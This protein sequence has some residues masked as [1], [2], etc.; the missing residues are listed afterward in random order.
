M[1]VKTEYTYDIFVSYNPIDQIWVDAYL[2]PRLKELGLASIDHRD[3]RV[4]VP[5]IVNIEH[6]IDNSRRILL[7]ITPEWLDDEWNEF[8]GILT[9]TSDPSGRQQRL[10][11]LILRPCQP[12]RRIS[13]LTLVDFTQPAR[14]DEEMGRLL[15]V[16]KT[17]SHILVNRQRV[18][19]S[20][21]VQ[22]LYGPPSNIRYQ[23][24]P[25]DQHFVGRKG[26]I[27]ELLSASQTYRV[28]SILGIPGVGKTALMR[29][30]VA[31]LDQSQVFW[32]EFRPGLL[33]L[34]DLLI[35][36]AR[37]LDSQSET[38]RF[39]ASAM[40]APTFSEADRISLVLS[41]L[42]ANTCSLFFDSVH[43]VER[44]SAIA[45]FLVLVKEQL[46]RGVVF[47][48]GRE[49]PAF[50]TAIDEARKTVYTVRLDGL[51][52][53]ET[54]EFVAHRR[55]TVPIDTVTMLHQRFDGLPL[56]LDLAVVLLTEN[57]TEASLLALA[58][59]A[60]EKTLDY[61]FDE[62][63]GQLDSTEKGLLTLASLFHFPFPQ[64]QLLKTYVSVFDRTDGKVGFA[65]LRRRLLIQ[66]QTA[67]LYE[68]HE[69]IRSLA[70][71]Y[72]DLLDQHRLRVAD[73]LV[74]EMPD[75]YE[76]QLEAITLYLEAGKY[77]QAA[78]LSVPIMEHAFIPYHPNLAETLLGAFSR[79]KVSLQNW[80]WLIGCKGNLARFWRRFEQ[81]ETHYR[82]MLNL[83]EELHDKA[84]V[85]VAFQRLGVLYLD[86]N[87][88]VAEQYCLDGLALTKELNDLPGQAQIYNNLGSLYVQQG[89]LSDAQMALNKGLDLLDRIG[90]PDWQKLS[91]YGNLGQLYAEQEQWEKAAHLHNR[92]LQISEEIKAPYEVALS[93]YNLGVD[94]NRQGN[95]ESAVQ[96][97]T[98]ALQLAKAHHLW[99]IEELVQIA[100][101]K[102]HDDLGNYDDAIACFRE[103]AKIQTEIDDKPRL[104]TTHFDIGTFYWRKTELQQ[105]LIFYEQGISIFEH[106]T[107]DQEKLELFLTNILHL[108]SQPNSARP[109]T[110]ALKQ[111]KNR[112]LAQSPSYAL[113]RV[114]GTLGEIYLECL[115]RHR[116]G[117]ACMQQA[118]TLFEKL[119]RWPEQTQELTKMGVKY[120]NLAQYANALNVYTKAIEISEQHQL[121][122]SLAI[123]HYNRAN[124][125]A[126]LE[127]WSHAESD[128]QYA[129]D[130]ATNIANAELQ[131]AIYHNIGE[132]YRRQGRLEDAKHLL[133]TS[134]EF[135]QRHSNIDAQIRA[136]NNLGLAYEES[137]EH[138][139]AL[140]C[141]D[142]ALA[143]CRQHYLKR[144]ESNVL[145]SLGNFYMKID[146]PD[147]AMSYYEEALAA[148]RLA[149]DRDM[150]E[151][152]MLSLAYAHRQLGTFDEISED[153]KATAERAGELRHYDNLLQFL[154]LAGQINLLDEQ[155]P[156]PAA[157]SFEQALAIG[158]TLGYRR[159]RQFEGHLEQ[160]NLVPELIEIFGQI[161][162]TIADA[163]QMT[164]RNLAHSFYDKLNDMIQNGEY[165]NSSGSW[166]M[167][168]LKPM[169]DY[170]NIM[171]EQALCEYV[172]AAWHKENVP[173]SIEPA[174]SDLNSSTADVN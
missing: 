69:V 52:L 142:L 3:F 29:Q 2:L 15:R 93:T 168:Y 4:G 47:A 43:R 23:E 7:I 126:T 84:A 48:A 133:R 134:L 19:A 152:S 136:L 90:G 169:G 137:S 148:A 30:I 95:Y 135:S 37:F 70:L 153:F 53:Q 67:E 120:E 8:E 164:D 57:F 13:M 138:Q 105:A 104:A 97:Y 159:V 85:A 154:I 14:W 149:E 129:L 82:T 20:Q 40:H 28:I 107:P 62:L 166:V 16:L 108:A 71:N 80:M 38:N 160:P 39:L 127:M 113:A 167:E 42:N 11:P 131:D 33:S 122:T 150:E 75:I 103:V 155:E 157:A 45:S 50:Y 65:K 60:Q 140:S 158:V 156:E 22:P 98:R 68:V 73:Y 110:N 141:F 55:I 146:Q 72:D 24:I 151:G 170:L 115:H 162:S 112:L 172:V 116:V 86:R 66:S 144:D 54:Q 46:H 59:K 41:R 36:L 27:K 125:Y 34:A 58:D 94:A 35:H 114:Y 128:Y 106:L 99:A 51:N 21:F 56:A 91:L 124:C 173:H 147:Q 165:W 78:E 5:R 12:P 64:D 31:Q 102:L 1:D 171:P 6:S 79:E 130:V 10:L 123:A 163:L 83:A 161:G 74:A 49:Q 132:T 109:I 111:L 121:L 44:D 100:L 87:R 18:A 61:L 81:A 17:T 117:L 32:Y 89:K 63:Y 139:E 25:I 88:E 96:Q 174:D 76:V 9:F 26:L 119:E 118:A 101:G 77:E 92:T 143:L 145:I